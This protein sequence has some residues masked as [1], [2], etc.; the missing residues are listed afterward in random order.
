[1]LRRN[2]VPG[3]A[4][5]DADGDELELVAVQNEGAVAAVAADR[6]A[7][8]HE[9]VVFADVDVK[10]YFVHPEGRRRVVLEVDGLWLWFSHAA[11]L[12]FL[13]CIA[14]R[15]RPTGVRSP[16]PTARARRAKRWH[17][18]CQPRA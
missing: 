17:A 10:V 3:R 9:R 6:E 5:I 4:A 11:I 1:L 12:A 7:P 2:L 18:I 8:P 15:A 13:L 16:L 14:G